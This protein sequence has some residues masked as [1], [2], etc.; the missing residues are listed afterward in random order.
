M[1][2]FF[3]FFIQLLNSLQTHTRTHSHGRQLRIGQQQQ[4]AKKKE[5][6]MENKLYLFERLANLFIKIGIEN[7]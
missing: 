6:Q 7:L 4:K 3:S 2:R 1:I 5:K